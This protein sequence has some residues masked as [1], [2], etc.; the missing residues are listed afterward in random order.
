L[1]SKTVTFPKQMWEKGVLYRYS[2]PHSILHIHEC[3]TYSV[4]IML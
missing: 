3:S 2:E 1:K 4:V